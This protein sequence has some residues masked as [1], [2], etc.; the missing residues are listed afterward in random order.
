LFLFSHFLW[1][2]VSFLIYFHCTASFL[3][4]FIIYLSLF[5]SFSVIFP[6]IA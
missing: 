4:P 3:F 5:I 1:S 6:F 2:F